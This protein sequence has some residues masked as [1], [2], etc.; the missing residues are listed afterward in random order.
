MP[1]PSAF[2]RAFLL[3]A[4]SGLRSLIST[5]L[6]SNHISHKDQKA[7]VGT[8]LAPLANETTSRVLA[9]LSAGEIVADKHPG[10]PARIQPAP[11]LAR[12]AFGA[13][14]GATVC[15]EEKES[16]VSGAV[17]GGLAA[18]VTTFGAYH[19]RQWL[20]NEVGLPD[21]AVALAEDVLAVA[22]G[23]QALPS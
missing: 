7:L 21:R 11:L 19:L 14:A 16:L 12:A 8:P 5:A 13:L 4:V 9:L 17:I 23:K 22:I 15:A 3:G 1:L 2:K 6:L 10:I 18:V 20:D